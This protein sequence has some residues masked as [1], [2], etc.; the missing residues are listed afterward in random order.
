MHE[1]ALVPQA[2]PFSTV[3]DL[4]Q[5]FLWPLLA[6][7][8]QR[9]T[10]SITDRAERHR[11]FAA[12]LAANGYDLESSML[13]GVPDLARAI[14]QYLSTLDD[15]EESRD[16]GGRTER[17]VALSDLMAFLGWALHRGVGEREAKP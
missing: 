14:A 11:W 6:R 5:F 4:S 13:V 2:Y 8:Q 12:C 7:R 9:D 17:E 10:L 3:E 16:A 15:V 1:K